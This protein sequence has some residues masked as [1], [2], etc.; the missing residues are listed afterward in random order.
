MSF[1]LRPL[2]WTLV[3]VALS[4]LTAFVVARKAALPHDHEDHH[5][6]A[7]PVS[8]VEGGTFHDWLHEKLALTPEQQAELEPIESSYGRERTELLARVEAAGKK[9]ADSL[10]G[11]P[12]N[13]EAI[14]VS[15]AEIHEAQ[16]LLQ[17]RTIGHFLE[18]KE[19]L[20]PEQAAK[21][22]QWTRES[23]THEH[24]P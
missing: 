2:A 21:L 5:H 11:S 23:I 3:A 4:A 6:A 8:G 9:L 10:D 18:M 14:D 19:H 17:E 24:Q 15:L 22:L 13:R 1:E 12:V 16:G 20:S 7:A